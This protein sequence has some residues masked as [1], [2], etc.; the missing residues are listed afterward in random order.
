MTASPTARPERGPRRRRRRGQEAR[1]GLGPGEPRLTAA[2]PMD[3]PD[4]SCKLTHQWPGGGSRPVRQS[5]SP[6]CC[7]YLTST[8]PKR[9][10]E[11]PACPPCISSLWFRTPAQEGGQLLNLGGDFSLFAALQVRA[12]AL[13]EHSCIGA[14]ARALV[15]LH[16]C[17]CCV[18]GCVCMCVY[19]CVRLCVCV[20]AVYIC[21]YIYVVCGVC[22]RASVCAC[23]C[24]VYVVCIYVCASV[25]VC[26][27]VYMCVCVCVCCVYVL[28]V[29]Q[30]RVG[31]CLCSRFFA[32]AAVSLPLQP[33]R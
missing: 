29:P 25:C 17:I 3:N 2:I 19:M 10:F 30:A 6:S 31:L 20:C 24:A 32:S 8:Q 14:V 23:V 18:H 16:L 21:V 28:A 15:V 4:C 26:R 33:F 1:S 22:V 9:W 13:C 5:R 27:G 12:Y 11:P 7:R